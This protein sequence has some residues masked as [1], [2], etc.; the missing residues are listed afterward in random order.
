MPDSHHPQEMRDLPLVV[1]PPQARLRRRE[2]AVHF[3]RRHVRHEELPRMGRPQVRV[4]THLLP[5]VEV[6][7][8]VVI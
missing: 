3:R 4:H 8:T 5:L 1:R 7:E 6:G 2:S